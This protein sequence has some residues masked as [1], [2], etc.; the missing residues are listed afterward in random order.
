MQ[1]VDDFVFHI[2]FSALDIPEEG[3]AALPNTS[4]R[5]STPLHYR[6]R[7]LENLL[8]SLSLKVAKTYLGHLLDYCHTLL[9]TERIVEAC[10]YVAAGKVSSLARHQPSCI[11]LLRPLSVGFQNNRRLSVS[12]SVKIQEFFFVICQSFERF[13]A[14]AIFA[15]RACH[16]GNFHQN[17][18]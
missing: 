10:P 16:S 1:I 13:V 17:C 8:D 14:Y 11:N 9:S 2:I 6:Y 15:W 5:R 3:L 4:S 12:Q 7:L 18:D